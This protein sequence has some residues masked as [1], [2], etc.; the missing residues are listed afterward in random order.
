LSEV[1][2]V[3]VALFSWTADM[4]IPVKVPFGALKYIGD[5]PPLGRQRLEEAIHVVTRVEPFDVTA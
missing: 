5:P 1:A 4:D 3:Q 2:N